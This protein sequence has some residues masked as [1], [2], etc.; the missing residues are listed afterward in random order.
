MPTGEE[1]T[2]LRVEA[3]KRYLFE[4]VQW[5]PDGEWVLIRDSEGNLLVIGAKGRPA[6]RALVSDAAFQ[7][8]VDHLGPYKLVATG[9]LAWLIP[10]NPT[11]TVSTPMK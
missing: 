4:D 11:Y 1:R 7:P 5:S 9:P 10:Q 8:V 3:G 6:S 2:L